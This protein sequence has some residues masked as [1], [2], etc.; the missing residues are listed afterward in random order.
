MTF[1]Y[2]ELDFPPVPEELIAQVKFSVGRAT[3]DSG[4]GIEHYQ[5]GKKL[6]PCG[7]TFG[8]V[9]NNDVVNWLQANIPPISNH[10]S[11]PR[12]TTK[13]KQIYVQSQSHYGSSEF[14]T[15]IVHSDY[16]R[17]AALNYHWA[18][19]GDSVVT[20]WYQDRSKSLWKNKQKPSRSEEHTS[21]L[22]SH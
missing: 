16:K 10:L 18:R 4:Y 3:N 19:G 17:L 12:A 7:Y 13:G 8:R 1:F 6:T 5:H 22:Q 15:H 14:S 21:E 9:I 20:R 2:K 11:N